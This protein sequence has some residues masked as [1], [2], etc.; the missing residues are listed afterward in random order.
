MGSN[1]EAEDFER[2]DQAKNIQKG[3][4]PK[5]KRHGSRNQHRHK[6]FVKW[7]VE[8]FDLNNDKPS[9]DVGVDDEDGSDRIIRRHILD[10]A[11]GKGEVSAR[12]CMC[13]N[14]RVIMVDPREADLV[15]CFEMQVVPKIPNKWQRRLTERKV[16]NPTFVQDTI[17]MR[18]Q[19]LVT[20]FDENTLSNSTELQEA[21]KNSKLILGLHADGAT[22]AIVNVA[23]EHNKPFVVVPCCVFPN[24]FTSRRVE[25]EDGI[26]VPV[27][28]HEQFCKYLAS[29]DERFQT[30]ELPFEGRNFAIW[31]DGK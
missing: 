17:S 21:V 8:T 15:Q 31:W 22:E 1:A 4:N 28:N 9:D 26:M 5:K 23:L 13:H 30:E 24:F 10:V 25:N 14:Q 3:K 11:G 12:L 2:E 6:S 16:E 29:K 20:T 27:R 19:Q 18:F 7:L